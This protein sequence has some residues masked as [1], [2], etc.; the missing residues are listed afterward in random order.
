MDHGD[1][2][3]LYMIMDHGGIYFEQRLTLTPPQQREAYTQ[4]GIR[5]SWHLYIALFGAL[6]K[7]TAEGEN[8]AYRQK[9]SAKALFGSLESFLFRR[10]G[11]ASIQKYGGR[12]RPT[13]SRAGHCADV[14]VPGLRCF[15]QDWDHA[16]F[17]WYPVQPVP[18]Q[19]LP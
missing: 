11:T 12:R 6:E 9:R 8:F 2:F 14:Q 15:G 7:K 1:M 13:V 4:S 5:Q 18:R 17:W 10:L 3:N 19:V 16:R